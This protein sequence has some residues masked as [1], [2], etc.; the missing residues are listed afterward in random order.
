MPGTYIIV[1]PSTCICCPN[2]FSPRRPWQRSKKNELNDAA[3]SYWLLA[4][5]L[6]LHLV[7]YQSLMSTNTGKDYVHEKPTGWFRCACAAY[8]RR[9]TIYDR[10]SLLL[11]FFLAVALFSDFLK[12]VNLR[13]R[14]CSMRP[15]IPTPCSR[16]N[17]P[18]SFLEEPLLV[19]VSYGFRDAGVEAQ[20]VSSSCTL[21]RVSRAN[22]VCSRCNT[23]IADARRDTSSPSQRRKTHAPARTLKDTFQPGR[24]IRCC[25]YKSPITTLSF[26]LQA[27]SL[28]GHS[29]DA[30]TVG[31]PCVRK[32][33]ISRRRQN[34]T[35]DGN[36]GET[37]QHTR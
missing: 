6:P 15:A 36:K 3:P 8:C 25:L 21:K 14:E 37:P 28:M 33:K 31:V 20:R 30:A 12:P 26:L 24:I 13:M 2:R 5:V 22:F 19:H 29:V 4:Y 27:Q 32:R 9:L 34:Y 1:P 17:Y 16:Q 11:V 23:R 7:N 35:S 10:D 18:N